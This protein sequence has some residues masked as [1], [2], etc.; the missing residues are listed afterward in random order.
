MLPNGRLREMISADDQRERL[1]SGE[2]VRTLGGECCQVT[3]VQP[4]TES[5]RTTPVYVCL[6]AADRRWEGL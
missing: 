5:A 6:K 3:G 4:M 1:N 2:Y